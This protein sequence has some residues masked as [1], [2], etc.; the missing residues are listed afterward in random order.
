MNNNV[1]ECNGIEKAVYFDPIVDLVNIDSF[2]PG[3]VLNHSYY[4]LY[5]EDA[6]PRWNKSV[7]NNEKYDSII[8]NGIVLKEHEEVLKEL[9]QDNIDGR[10]PYRV[11]VD[12]VINNYGMIYFLKYLSQIFTP[13]TNKLLTHN[14]SIKKINDMKNNALLFLDVKGDLWYYGYD[15]RYG[16]VGKEYE[17]GTK[18]LIASEVNDFWSTDSTLLYR[19]EYDK[20]QYHYYARGDNN[21]N[22]FV[23]GL[24]YLYLNTDDALIRFPFNKSIKQIMSTSKGYGILLDD[25]LFYMTG[26]NTMLSNTLTTMRMIDDNVKRMLCTNGID[27][28]Y[29]KNEDFSDPAH[30]GRLYVSNAKLISNYFYTEIKGSPFISLK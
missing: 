24:N 8:G 13:Y 5:D 7:N 17:S 11:E 25:D 1:F 20:N 2:T 14:Q 16:I 28:C 26:P 22:M 29:V 23:L 12:R 18:V 10:F 19:K 4:F 3:Y 21:D 15:D 30:L 27:I 9:S 6:F